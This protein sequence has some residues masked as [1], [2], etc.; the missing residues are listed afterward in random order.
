MEEYIQAIEQGEPLPP[1]P[2][3]EVR[4][5]YS[6]REDGVGWAGMRERPGAGDGAAEIVLVLMDEGAAEHLACWVWWERGVIREHG[7][8]AGRCCLLQH[9]SLGNS[10]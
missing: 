7:R 10:F 9:P 4:Q 6:R 3:G 2:Q 1:T 8:A 5:C